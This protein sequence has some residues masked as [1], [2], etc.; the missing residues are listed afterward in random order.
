ME[1]EKLAKELWRLVCSKGNDAVKLAY[2]D[3]VGAAGI[4]RLDLRGVTE[5]KRSEKGCF[6]VRFVDKLRAVELL[7]QL[8]EK[9]TGGAEMD[10]FLQSLQGD[11]Q[12]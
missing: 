11:E 3:E 1:R 10:R 2:L 4:G 7:E 8:L 9:E 6:E 12:M 5:I